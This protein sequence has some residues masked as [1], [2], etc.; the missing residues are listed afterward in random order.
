MKEKE[1]KILKE[2]R[3]KKNNS[4]IELK[5]KSSSQRRKMIQVRKPELIKKRRAI[6]K[7]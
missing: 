5:R 7:E 1:K 6:G 2:T 4:L 3:G